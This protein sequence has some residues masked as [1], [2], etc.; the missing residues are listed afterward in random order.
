MDHIEA[1][2]SNRLS[3]FPQ[4][5]VHYECVDFLYIPVRKHLQ[6]FI[7]VNARRF[8]NIHAV[9]RLNMPIILAL[10]IMQ[11]CYATPWSNANKSLTASNKMCVAFF[12][13]ICARK[14][15]SPGCLLYNLQEEITVKC[16]LSASVIKAWCS[17]SLAL[18][19]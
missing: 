12:Y 17:F 1:R 16:I 19:N 10:Y 2:S 3:N 18:Q 7:S 4:V 15:G 5:W 9:I 8:L 14:Q 11:N 13:L 6:K